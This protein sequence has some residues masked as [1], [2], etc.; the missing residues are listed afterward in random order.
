MPACHHLPHN[1]TILKLTA[2]EYASSS[3]SRRAKKKANLHLDSGADPDPISEGCERTQIVI[4]IFL[5]NRYANMALKIFNY[6]A[7]YASPRFEYK[8]CTDCTL[9]MLLH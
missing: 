5:F 9:V 1:D 8:H 7:G 2:E 4:S 6:V 3:E